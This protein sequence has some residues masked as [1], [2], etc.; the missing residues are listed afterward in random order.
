MVTYD[1]RPQI[2]FTLEPKLVRIFFLQE[3]SPAAYRSNMNH[4]FTEITVNEAMLSLNHF[5][6]NFLLETIFFFQYRTDA[7]IK[8]VKQI[9][10]LL[11]Y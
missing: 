2:S 11:S 1:N 5:E 6:R 8:F 9:N 3:Q 7:N 4:C 10:Q